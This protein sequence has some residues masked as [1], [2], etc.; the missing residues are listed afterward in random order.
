M[1]GDFAE[2]AH[3]SVLRRTHVIRRD[4]QRGVGAAG[5][6]PARRG[7]CLARV[8][9]AGSGE[10]GHAS[11]HAADGERQQPLEFVGIER[12]RLAGG[13]GDD[14]RLRAAGQLP[15]DEPAERIQIE[16]IRTKRRRQSANT[17]A[18][19]LQV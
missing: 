13:T 18:E 5:L 1:V 4:D 2:V 16:R 19:F 6:R 17:A 15:I 7:N 12:M 3:E 9:G 14:Q 8:R 10:H 11:G